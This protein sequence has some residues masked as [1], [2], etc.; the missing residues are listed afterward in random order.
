MAKEAGS[1]SLYLEFLDSSKDS[2]ATISV[3]V[4]TIEHQKL[5]LLLIG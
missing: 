3:F 1:M 5:L 2:V 4:N